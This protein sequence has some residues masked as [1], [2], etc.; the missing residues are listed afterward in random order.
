[1]HPFLSRRRFVLK[2]VA[3]ALAVPALPSLADDAIGKR[4]VADV[5][6][7]AGVSARRFVA[8]GNLLGF[9]RKQLFPEAVGKEFETTK[10]LEPLEPVR[11]RM[12]LYRGLNH[13]LKGGPRYTPALAAAVTPII[14]LLVVLDTFIG[15]RIALSIAITLNT[16]LPIPSSP[17]RTPATYIMPKPSGTRVTL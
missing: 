1:M 7:G 13:G 4:S 8:I 5:A 3:G 10:L 12:T 9:Q 16:P 14:K 6:P 15:I 17:E 2:S 11:D